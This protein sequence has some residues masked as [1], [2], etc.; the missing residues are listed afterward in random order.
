MKENNYCRQ[1]PAGYTQAFYLNCKDFK[2]GLVFTL[3]SLVVL[4]AVL[5]LS[6]VPLL[7]GAQMG[8]A[9]EFEGFQ[10]LGVTYGFLA[11]MI[12]YIVLHELVHGIFY[13]ALTGEKLTFGIS[14]SCAFCGVPN[15]YTSRR[16]SLLSASAPLIVFTLIMLP[17]Q[18]AFF[19]VHPLLYWMM[20]FIF[21]IHLG[22]CCGD[23][24]LILL[25]LV[26]FKNPRTLIRDTGPEQYIYVP[27]SE[28]RNIA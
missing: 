17:V 23:G 25:L 19:F 11:L 27:V 13:K 12:V 5:A 2:V 21:G 6:A 3:V 28:E 16:T 22:G 10:A 20:A 8:H 7:L 15:I 9:V 26:R 1:L 4:V 24:F 14:W 18:I